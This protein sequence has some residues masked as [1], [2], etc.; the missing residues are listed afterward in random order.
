MQ[1]RWLDALSWG[2][3]IYCA[4]LGKNLTTATPQIEEINFEDREGVPSRMQKTERI[5]F[6]ARKIT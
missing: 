3:M 4:M 5:H 1:T 2:E 6:T